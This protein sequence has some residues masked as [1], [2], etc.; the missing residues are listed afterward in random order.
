VLAALTAKHDEA[1]AGDTMIAAEDAPV[2]AEAPPALSDWRAAVAEI[3]PAVSS[4]TRLAEQ[5]TVM[6]PVMVQILAALDPTPHLAM[7]R[8]DDEEPQLRRSAE[9]LI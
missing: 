7:P 9:G 3:A 5:V 8:A 4:L 1:P 6:A 2:A